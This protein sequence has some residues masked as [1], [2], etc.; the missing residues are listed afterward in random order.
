MPPKKQTEDQVV[1]ESSDDEYDN[2]TM[3]EPVY[4]I[5]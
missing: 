5:L 3:D 4:P 1:H 2:N